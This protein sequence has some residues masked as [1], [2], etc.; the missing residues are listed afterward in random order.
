MSETI[1]EVRRFNRFY[2]RELG[3]LD[4]GL[5]RSPFSLPEAR[6]LYELASRP[7][8]TAAEI[9]R[10]LRMDK[11]QLSRILSRFEA[12]GM[13]VA[14]TSPTH[15]R[16]RLLTLTRAGRA[17]FETL[18]EGTVAHV[19]ALLAPL[20][21]RSKRRLTA[22][23]REIRSLLGERAPEAGGDVTLRS[24]IPGDLGWVIH[25]QAILYAEEYGW[26]W[27]YEGLIAG[28][29]GQFVAT[30]DA[31]REGA[32]IA[33]AGGSIAG[34]VFLMRSE[35]P[36]TA[37]LRLL[38]VEPGHRGLGIGRRLV[39]A[40]IERARKAGYRTLALWTNDVLVSARRIYEAAGFRLVGEEPHRSFGHD[41]VAQTWE[42]ALKP[43]A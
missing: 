9:S 1:E 20:G 38:Y 7:A 11:A 10:T 12:G 2:T 25:R 41:L 6:T 31:E 29:L 43:A 21:S 15:A 33:E 26:D 28:I 27:T 37:K 4:E 8:Q 22:A 3:L 23:M 30:F 39:D 34:S 16:Q 42:L 24:P 32:W 19:Q 17:A 13:V 36:A 5:T 35:D 14:E 18:N 40:C